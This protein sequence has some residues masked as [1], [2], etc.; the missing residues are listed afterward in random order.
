M[1][2]IK[3]RVL[4]SV[5]SSVIV[6]LVVSFIRWDI[7]WIRILPNLSMDDRG[8]AISMYLIIQLFAQLFLFDER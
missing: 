1:G 4:V 8:F 6:Y 3:N 2:K 5:L 7:T